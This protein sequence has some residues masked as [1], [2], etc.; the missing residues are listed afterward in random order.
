MSRLLLN[1]RNVPDDEADDVRALLDSN[2]IAF[3]ETRPS[4]WGISAGAI[5]VT[6]DA[7][8]PEAKRLMA[9][10]QEQRRISARAEYAAAVRDG[11]AET[12]WSL[13]RAEPGRV[14]L[15]LLAIAFLLGLVALPVYLLRG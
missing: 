3:H 14:L 4:M 6:E 13:L 9:G 12:F 1:L 2:R 11:T 8:I 15:T 7:S 5:F 10:Y